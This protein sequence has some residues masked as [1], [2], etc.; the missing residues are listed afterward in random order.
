MRRLLKNIAE[1]DELGD[2]TTL[3]DPAI[4]DDLKQKADRALGRTTVG[5]NPVRAPR[6][7]SGWL[8]GACVL[9]LA[10]AGTVDAARDGEA[11]AHPQRGS[12]L[13]KPARRG[14]PRAARAG[15]RRP[16][17]LAQRRRRRGAAGVSDARLRQRWILG[18]AGAAS[19]DLWAAPRGELA[20]V[21][22]ARPGSRFELWLAQLGEVAASPP[23]ASGRPEGSPAGS[24]DGT[25]RGLVQ[26]RGG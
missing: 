8:L 1:G 19:C 25:R 20:L 4:V 13:R 3:R 5:A 18:E 16:R 23:A 26:P 7:W 24:G 10:V 9:G 14:A 11:E 6:G 22:A 12:S 17:R 21:S 15:A 2:T